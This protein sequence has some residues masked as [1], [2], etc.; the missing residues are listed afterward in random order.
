M[1]D[2]TYVVEITTGKSIED[3]AKHPPE[4]GPVASFATGFD[5]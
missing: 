3:V 2:E 5:S 1:F 4:S